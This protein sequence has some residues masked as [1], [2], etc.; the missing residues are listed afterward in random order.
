M[1]WNIRQAVKNDESQINKLFIEMLQTIYPNRK[2]IGGFAKE[3][4]ISTIIFHVEKSNKSAFKLYKRLGYSI[5]G[6]E[7]TRLKMIKRSS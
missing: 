7:E 2:N 4:D 3:I 1:E 6:D 5:M